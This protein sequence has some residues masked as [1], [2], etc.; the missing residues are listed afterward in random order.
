[1]ETLLLFRLA[2]EGAQARTEEFSLAREGSRTKAVVQL[3]AKLLAD[4]VVSINTV[5]I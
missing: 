3:L 1:M 2:G 4:S 5:S